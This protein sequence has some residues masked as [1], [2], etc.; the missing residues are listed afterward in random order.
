MIQA[1]KR[2]SQGLTSDTWNLKFPTLKSIKI[3]VP[4]FDEQRRISNTFNQVDNML[5]LQQTKIDQLNKLKQAYLQK[6]FP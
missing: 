3:N 5:L 1:F 6:L 4:H 2:N